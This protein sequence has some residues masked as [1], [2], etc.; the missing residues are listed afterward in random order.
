MPR[1]ATRAPLPT[2]RGRTG[3]RRALARMAAGTRSCRCPVPSSS[4]ARWSSSPPHLHAGRA[5]HVS[6]QAFDVDMQKHRHVGT[7]VADDHDQ[8]LAARGSW[9]HIAETDDPG[10]RPS[11]WELSSLPIG[12]PAARY[13][14]DTP[15]GRRSRPCADRVPSRTR[16]TR[17]HGPSRQGV[18]GR[19]SRTTLL[20]VAGQ[21]AGPDRQPPRP[22]PVVPAPRHRRPAPEPRDPGAGSR[23]R[24]TSSPR[25]PQWSWRDRSPRYRCRCRTSPP[26][27][28]QR[29][30]IHRPCGGTSVAGSAA[31]IRSPAARRGHNR[32]Y[33]GR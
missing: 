7:G 8:V 20:P 22:V 2:C 14:V 6:G 12:R 33:A 19:R 27:P 15:R 5:E 13:A 16:P 25:A 21:P 29:H 30:L 17:R 11:W 9:V 24:P 28:G 1:S 4:S 31:H 10:V 26:P 23:T 3:R 18:R 32:R